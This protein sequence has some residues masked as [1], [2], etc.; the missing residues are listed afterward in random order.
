ME[1]KDLAKMNLDY[2]R[3]NDMTTDELNWLAVELL[4]YVGHEQLIEEVKRRG[5]GFEL[6][7]QNK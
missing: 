7:P 6:K 2:I 4:E 5:F 3:Q 1:A